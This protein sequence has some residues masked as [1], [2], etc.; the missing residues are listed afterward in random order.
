MKPQKACW[1]EIVQKPRPE[2]VKETR[3]SCTQTEVE[4]QLPQIDKMEAIIKDLCGKIE[5]L[6]NK[7]KM[8]TSDSTSAK[9]RCVNKNKTND[10]STSD[11][12]DDVHG[13][14][15]PPRTLSKKKRFSN[16]DDSDWVSNKHKINAFIN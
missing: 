15:L 6:E 11:C 10:Q 12:S 13:Q 4:Y 14:Y 5:T 16:Q 8:Q 2:D 7:L 3:D 1:S 9:N